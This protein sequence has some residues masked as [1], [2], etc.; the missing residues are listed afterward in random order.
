M[1]S[2]ILTSLEYPGVQQA[3]HSKSLTSLG[4]ERSVQVLISVAHHRP[5]P[6][7]LSIK[8]LDCVASKCPLCAKE[9]K[10]CLVTTQEKLSLS[11]PHWTM[12]SHIASEQKTN[13]AFILH[14]PTRL[15]S[16]FMLKPL[17]CLEHSLVDYLLA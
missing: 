4:G 9:K 3:G 2:R 8:A 13:D 16:K 12:E 15:Q 7:H 1:N 17:S 5:S 14:D 10:N 11:P 6:A